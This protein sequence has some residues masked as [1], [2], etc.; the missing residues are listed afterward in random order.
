M[1]FSRIFLKESVENFLFLIL[2]FVTTRLQRA[3]HPD[4]QVHDDHEGREG[5]RQR[6]PSHLHGLRASH[7]RQD[8]Q[9]QFYLICRDF[10]LFYP[11]FVIHSS[12]YS[13]ISTI[14]DV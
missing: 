5:G 7:P 12:S 6:A 4:R 3:Q 2:F 10:S 1:V 11:E 13:L 14:R 8:L 9:G